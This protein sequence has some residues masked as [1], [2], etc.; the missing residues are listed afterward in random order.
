MVWYSCGLTFADDPYCMMI[1]SECSFETTNYKSDRLEIDK[2][3][4]S[5]PGNL[6]KKIHEKSDFFF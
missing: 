5:Y 4:S 6:N 2:K 3:N 1:Q